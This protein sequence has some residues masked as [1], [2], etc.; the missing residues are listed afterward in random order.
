MQVQ[1]QVVQFW[2]VSCYEFPKQTKTQLAD[3]K[4]KTKTV[5]LMMM[6]GWR[7][8]SREGDIIL[9]GMM[10]SLPLLS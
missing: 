3:K 10:M 8:L 7:Y 4:L 9:L 5:T 6:D 1:F 2:D